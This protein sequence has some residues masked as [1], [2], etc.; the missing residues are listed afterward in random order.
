MTARI[1]ITGSR[2]WT[3]HTRIREVLGR[4]W[5]RY[6]DAV[7]VHGAARGADRIAAALWR[8]W[9]LPT[10]AHP[11]DWNRHGKAAGHVRNRQMVALG[12]DVCVAFIRDGSPGATA[13]T[14]LAHQAGIPI[15]LHTERTT[16][17]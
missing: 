5:A 11:A 6:P 4:W 10:E 1:L 13:C 14:A 12:A 15:D 2:T 8:G 17:P 7:L 3:N 9:G 16:Q